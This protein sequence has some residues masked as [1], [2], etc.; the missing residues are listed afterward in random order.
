MSA[1]IVPSPAEYDK[2]LQQL[3]D[4]ETNE[5]EFRVFISA[6]V[7]SNIIVKLPNPKRQ[8]RSSK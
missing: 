3:N 2:L 6:E 5:I 8:V 7:Y 1:V 4:Q